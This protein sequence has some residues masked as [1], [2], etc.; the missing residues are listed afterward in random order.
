MLIPTK[1][2][3]GYSPN[4]PLFSYVQKV[5]SHSHAVYREI[6]V[7]AVPGKIER[8]M[9]SKYTTYFSNF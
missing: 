1:L 7:M 5:D 9:V 4:Q 8:V 2:K 6:N 3:H